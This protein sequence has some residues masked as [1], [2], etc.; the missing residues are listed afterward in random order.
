MVKLIALLV[1]VTTGLLA[2]TLILY[3]FPV[4][5]LAGIVEATVPALTEVKAPIATGLAKLPL[6]SLNSAVKTLPGLK[7]PV[8]V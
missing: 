5:A 7:V 3:P 1:P 4:A 8:F 6:A 2:T